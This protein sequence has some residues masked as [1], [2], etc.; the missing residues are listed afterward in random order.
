MFRMAFAS[1]SAV[2][3]LFQLV[4]ELPLQR[5]PALPPEVYRR[6]VQQLT[7]KNQP[8]TGDSGS[9]PTVTGGVL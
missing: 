8:E 9:M 4:A 5:G 7:Y 6:A 1:L 3:E 2:R